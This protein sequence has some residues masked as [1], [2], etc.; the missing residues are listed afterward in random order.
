MKNIFYDLGSQVA[1]KEL[2]ALFVADF[3]LGWLEQWK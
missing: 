3:L 1:H 2:S